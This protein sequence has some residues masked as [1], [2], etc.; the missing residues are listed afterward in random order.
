MPLSI[1][2]W[3]INRAT[4][5]TP[6]SKRLKIYF[7]GFAPDIIILTETHEEFI[8]IEGYF[9]IHSGTPDYSHADGERMCSIWSKVPVEPL[10]DYMSDPARCTAGRIILT[11]N[12]AIV[13]CAIVLPWGGDRWQGHSPRDGNAFQKA[14]DTYRVDWRIL[15]AQF[16]NDDFILAGDFNQD[17]IADHYYG[18]KDQKRIMREALLKDDLKPLTADTNDPV[19]RDSPPHACIDHICI[20]EPSGFTLDSVV[21]WPD[22]PAPDLAFSD[23]FAIT[24]KLI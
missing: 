3:N 23:H 7:D 9:G 21:R 18:S 5:S 4:P 17:L 16:P 6:Q 13:V 2:N 12:H 20:S 8:P 22:T 11:E 1:T 14:L 10:N 19:Y 15:R 24:A